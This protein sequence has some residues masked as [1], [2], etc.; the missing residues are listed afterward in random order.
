MLTQNQKVNKDDLKIEEDDTGTLVPVP[1][2]LVFLDNLEEEEEAF[3]P[4]LLLHNFFRRLQYY[5]IY[6]V[7]L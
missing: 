5:S 1:Y 2:L 3:F 6:N 7:H 4:E